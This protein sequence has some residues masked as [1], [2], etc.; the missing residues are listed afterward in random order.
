MTLDPESKKKQDNASDSFAEKTSSESTEELEN[1][2][3]SSP[4]ISK[5]AWLFLPFLV[6]TIVIAGFLLL[7]KDSLP[8]FEELGEFQRGFM[9]AISKNQKDAS[10][11][12]NSYIKNKAAESGGFI[13]LAELAYRNGQYEDARLNYSSAIPKITISTCTERSVICKLARMLLLF[14]TALLLRV[15]E[16]KAFF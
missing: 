12:A 16:H 11:Y 5:G 15:R 1:A 4:E 9:Q 6:L 7:S 3:V 13:Q 14:K 2:K 8:G 10:D